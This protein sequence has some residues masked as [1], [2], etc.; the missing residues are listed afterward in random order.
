MKRKRLLLWIILPLTFIVSV[1]WLFSL[2]LECGWLRR[3][4][5]AKLAASFGRPVEVAHFGFSIVGGP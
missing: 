5:S 4:L 2:A 3:P 1:S